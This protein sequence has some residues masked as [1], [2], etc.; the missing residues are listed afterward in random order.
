MGVW[1]AGLYSGDFAMDLRSAAVA[2]TRLPFDGDRLAELLCAVE[3]G[4]SNNPEDEDYTTFWLVVADQF[5]KKGITCARVQEKSLEIIDGGSDLAMLSKLGMDAE[6]LGKRQKMLADLRRLLTAPP[7]PAKPRR[8]LKK[9]QPLLMIPG[10]T[11]TYPTCGGKQIN[12][13]FATKEQMV[14]AWR[15]DGWGAAVIVECGR[16]FDFFAWYVPLTIAVAL[17]HK[18]DIEHL[19]SVPLW[20]LRRPGTCTAAHFKKMELE[21][22]A[23]VPISVEKLDRS[24]PARPNGMSDALSDISIANRLSVGPSFRAESIHVP[25]QPVNS[26]WERQYPGIGGLDE[27]LF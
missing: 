25:G 20:A 2:V 7:P 23:T 4:A 18:P 17:P 9:P 5:A 1:G 6:E 12:P 19:R 11:L 15:Q 16:A 13:Y 8:V 26:R 10:D 22:I 24:F 27:I 14:P 21:K 3:P